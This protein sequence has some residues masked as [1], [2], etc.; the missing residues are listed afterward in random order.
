MDST[1][2]RVA[3]VA[4][5]ASGDLLAGLLL[6]GLTK[7]W[8]TL[9]PFGIG[10]PKMAAHGFEAWWQ[11]DKLAVRGYVEVLSTTGRSPESATSS[12]NAC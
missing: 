10:G 2:P 9:K 6:G 5:E 1:T 11:H 3:M 8:P 4:G 7:R 12:P